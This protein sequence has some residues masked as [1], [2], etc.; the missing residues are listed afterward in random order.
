MRLIINLRFFLM[1]FIFLWMNLMEVFFVGLPHISLLRLKNNLVQL[2]DTRFVYLNI[3][4]LNTD[5]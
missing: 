1:N 4:N 3:K 5:V 2:F